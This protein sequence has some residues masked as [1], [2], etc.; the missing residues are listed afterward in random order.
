MEMGT[1]TILSAR[2][3]IIKPFVGGGELFFLP[4]AQDTL[5]T[6]LHLKETVAG[7]SLI[8]YMG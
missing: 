3:K 7:I 8:K 6:Q 2:P 1:K 5:A 4:R